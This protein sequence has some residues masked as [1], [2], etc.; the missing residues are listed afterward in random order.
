MAKTHMYIYILPSFA[1]CSEVIR[2]WTEGLLK[3]NVAWGKSWRLR[4]LQT[5]MLVSFLYHER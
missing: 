5:F 4:D 3:M 2:G 1:I